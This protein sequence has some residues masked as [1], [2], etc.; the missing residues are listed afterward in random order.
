MSRLEVDP[1]AAQVGRHAALFLRTW[2][3]ISEESDLRR[4]LAIVCEAAAP[5]VP[6]DGVVLVG[7]HINGEVRPRAMFFSPRLDE[8]ARAAR[9]PVLVL[10][11]PGEA[12]EGSELTRQVRARRPYLCPD[13]LARPCW[14]AH[15]QRMA[16]V[17]VRSYATLPLQVRGLLVGAATFVRQQLHPFSP[18]EQ[19]TLEELAR[20]LAVALDGSM[21]AERLQAL[22]GTTGEA[23]TPRAIPAPPGETPGTPG[24]V[25]RSPGWRQV[26]AAVDEV[27][28]TEVTVLVTGET[29]TGKEQVVAALHRRSRRARGPLVSVH[30]AAIPESLIAAELFGHEPG[31]FTGAGRRRKGR[32]EQAH[33]GTLFLDEVGELAPAVQVMLLRAL[34]ERT[35]ERLGGGEPV[36]VDVRLVAAT[37]RDLLAEVRAGRFRSDLY[38]RLEV[39][40][41]HVG[42]LRERRL[43]IA[44][45]AEHFIAKH[46]DGRAVEG[47]E[48]ETLAALEAHHWP[49]NVRELENVIQRAL[50]RW[51]GGPL[52]L[53]GELAP[54]PPVLAAAADLRLQERQAIEAALAASRGKVSGPAGAAVRFGIPASTLESRIRR[55]QIDKHRFRTR[56]G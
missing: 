6:F 49:G 55:L 48:R 45:L 17:G 41:I 15:E 33:G 2:R 32:F 56:R 20:P 18:A 19:A 52:R 7:G 50:I 34:Q 16:E 8:V 13:L 10:S 29:G 26:M 3:A 25:G 22:G 27:A 24:P 39:F 53:A 1:A 11:R 9:K 5:S 12:Y 40:P 31:A 4:V 37:N 23:T 38:Y 42:P 44:P 51:R 43:D 30:C 47:I 46:G 36:A 14:L 35:V 28:P 54:P 21:T